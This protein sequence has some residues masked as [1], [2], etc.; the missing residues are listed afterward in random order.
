[1]ILP[2]SQSSI[3]QEGLIPDPRQED[4]GCFMNLLIPTTGQETASMWCV[5][6]LNQES[7]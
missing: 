6:K 5:T 4:F 2:M 3:T 7:H 1:M